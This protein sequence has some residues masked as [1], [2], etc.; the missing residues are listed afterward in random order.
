M[1]V[2]GYDPRPKHRS[3]LRLL[4]ATCCRGQNHANSL[5][6]LLG[7]GLDNR[8]G[9]GCQVD[10]LDLDVELLGLDL[11]TLKFLFENLDRKF[12]LRLLA[13]NASLCGLALHACLELGSA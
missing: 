1:A 8:A 11:K 4:P 7:L 13:I 5:G 9:L 3:L 6:H 12:A 10:F 2:P